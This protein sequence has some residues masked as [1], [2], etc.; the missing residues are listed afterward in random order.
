MLRRKKEVDE[1]RLEPGVSVGYHHKEQPELKCAGK[2]KQCRKNRPYEQG[3][4]ERRIIQHRIRY[5]N[6][7]IFSSGSDQQPI[8]EHLLR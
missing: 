2:S 5:H 4:W 8:D 7:R 6:Q 3:Y 1:E